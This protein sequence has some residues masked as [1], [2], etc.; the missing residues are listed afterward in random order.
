VEDRRRIARLY[1][2]AL[3]GLPV[4]LQTQPAWARTNWQS[5]CL[6]FGSAEQAARVAKLLQAA[7]VSSRP[8]VMNAHEEPAYAATSVKLPESERAR[9]QCLIVPVVDGMSPQ[10]I[11]RVVAPIRSVC[12]G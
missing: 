6:R 3:A 8:G 11:V 5:L 9:R 1:A 7:A 10:D 2:E 12:S 4:T